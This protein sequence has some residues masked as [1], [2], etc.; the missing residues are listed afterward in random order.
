MGKGFS[1]NRVGHVGIHVTDMDR[2]LEW[3]RD[4]LGLTLTGRWPLGGPGKELAFMRFD[5][6]HHNIVLFTHPTPVD[7]ETWDSGFNGLQHIAMEIEDRDEWLKALADLQR[8]EVEI[9]QGPLVHGFEGGTGPGTNLGGSGSRSFYFLDPDGNRLEL[10]TEM[11][12]V[13]N[14]DEFPTPDYAD[15]VERIGREREAAKAAA[16]RS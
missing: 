6:D 15:A 7:A 9:V 16:A 3:Y 12:K 14:G 11:M 13:P 8:K 10:F 2:S 5:D 4:I 1:I